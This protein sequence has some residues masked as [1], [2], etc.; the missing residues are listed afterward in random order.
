MALAFGARTGERTMRTPSVRNTSSKHPGYFESRSWIRNRTPPRRSSMA[1]LRACW[2]THA[3]SGWAVTPAMWTRLGRKLDEEQ[4]EERSQHHGLDG[5]EVGCEDAGCLGAQER[6][7]V[8][9]RSAGGRARSRAPEDRADRGRAD[10]NPELAELALDADAPPPTVLPPQ[11]TDPGRGSLDRSGVGRACPSCCSSISSGSAPGATGAGS[12]DAPGTGSTGHE[13]WL[14]SRRRAPPCRDAA[15][16]AFAAGGGGASPRDEGRC[17]PA[18]GH[19]WRTAAEPAQRPTHEE[20]Q[21]EAHRRILE[22]AAPGANL[23]YSRPIPHGYR[24]P[25]D[26][27]DRAPARAHD[28][29]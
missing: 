5:E 6:T 24:N 11:S 1:R 19:G 13:G 22:D 29:G 2:V 14:G 3:E 17:S 23:G 4:H 28:K 20:I 15:G 12:G 9:V 18:P 26:E 7:P 10:A 8:R 16:R 25:R 27:P 21:E